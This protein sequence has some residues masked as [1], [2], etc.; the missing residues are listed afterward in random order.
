MDITAEQ[1]ILNQETAEDVLHQTNIFVDID[2]YVADLSQHD[3]DIGADA[4]KPVS[5]KGD[6][7]ESSSDGDDGDED[8]ESDDDN[9]EDD[10]SRVFNEKFERIGGKLVLKKSSFQPGESSRKRRLDNDDDDAY[11]PEEEEDSDEIALRPRRSKARHDRPVLPPPPTTTT[12]VSVSTPI[13]TTTTPIITTAT[14]S[15]TPTPPVSSFAPISAERRISILEH[16]VSELSSTVNTLTDQLAAQKASS[17]EKID[18]LN[19][20]VVSLTVRAEAQRKFMLEL[21]DMLKKLAAQGEKSSCKEDELRRKDDE[22]RDDDPSAPKESELPGSSTQLGSKL[23]TV[24]GESGNGAGISGEAPVDEEET[25]EALLDL[26]EELTVSDDELEEGEFAPIDVE[27]W[28]SDEEIVDDKDDDI[29]EHVVIQ[30][31][32]TSVVMEGD[33]GEKDINLKEVSSRIFEEPPVDETRDVEPEAP[34]EN[35]KKFWFKELPKSEE[36][37]F[38]QAINV[39]GAE[40]LKKGIMSWFYDSELRLFVLKRYDGLQY[41]KN[42]RKSFNSLPLCELKELARMKLIN[43]GDD[44]L[45]YVLERI[46]KREVFSNKF[47]QLSPSKGKRVADKS[48]IDPRTNKP[49]MKM[50][51]KPV[52]CLKQV[53]L[54]K[55]PQNIL[56]NVKWWYV[57]KDT[58][59]AVMQDPDYNELLRVYDPLHLVNLS[60][61]DLLKL[62]DI[63][64]LCMDIW[65]SE[66]KKYQNVVRVCVDKNVHAGI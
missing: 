40:H 6:S 39:T 65:K 2:Q 19:T 49:W 21:E 15:S 59:E 8:T 55:M 60:R 45:A 12:T 56:A 50:V 24:Q 32:L 9:D 18:T 37:A 14:I 43:L 7:T 61:D 52:K 29:N 35:L 41:L 31:N 58:G 10:A 3:D 54:K 47:E 20:H 34:N 57:D 17:Q 11:L 1:N 26:D 28:K 30:H 4:Q 63:K 5:D 46:I 62:N 42:N 22:D 27:E 16:Q 13:L 51:Y 36:I 48:K 23:S 25:I 44:P 38:K 66:A 33:E 64:I 53:P